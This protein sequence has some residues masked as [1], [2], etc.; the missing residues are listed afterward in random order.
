MEFTF[1]PQEEQFRREVRGFF[2]REVAP[3]YEHP[4]LAGAHAYEEWHIALIKAIARKLGARGWLGLG[5]P[6][7]YGGRKATWKE[8]LIF[9]E[10]AGYY[11][12][13]GIPRQAVNMA[14][15]VIL[16]HGSEEQKRRL[17]PPIARGE[18]W[19][20]QGYSEPEAGSDLANLQTRAAPDGD[21]FRVTGQKIWTSRA[22]YADYIFFL[23]RSDA[24]A[25]RHRGISFLVAEMGTPGIEARAITNMTGASDDFSEVFFTDAHVPRANWI[26]EEGRGWYLAMA[27]LGPER[28]QVDFIATLR[29]RLDDLT[30]YVG[31]TTRNGRPLARDPLVRH[32]LVEMEIEWQMGRLMNYRVAWLAAMGEQAGA[33]S[34][35]SKAIV[36]PLTQ[37]MARV[38]GQVMGLDM[39]LGGYGERA[40]RAPLEGR[41]L[42]F[43]LDSV[44]RTFNAGTHEVQLNLIATRGLGLPAG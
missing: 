26:G 7:E 32:R 33:A 36:G 19:W 10:E 42:R 11:E 38:A 44:S 40:H 3:H 9:K 24:Q 15:P 29:R 8:Q 14:A 5:W 41:L 23:A 17:L 43:Y 27:Q 34:S 35:Q 13:W 31:E 4:E 30:R 21:V 12:N 25:Q 28:A 39:Q 16:A 20:C 6:E 2:A 22:T 37:R 18:S 1:S